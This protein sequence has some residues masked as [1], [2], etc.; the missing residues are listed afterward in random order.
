M[1]RDA[2]CARTNEL[3]HDAPDEAMVRVA[4]TAVRAPGD[5]R[6]GMEPLQFVLHPCGQPEQTRR[7]FHV[8]AQAGVRKSQQQRR[9]R[10]ESVGGAPGFL[11]A[12]ARQLRAARN[13]GVRAALRAVGRDDQIDT[14][15]LAARIGAAAPSSSA[16]AKI[17]TSVFDAPWPAADPPQTSVRAT[18]AINAAIRLFFMTHLLKRLTSRPKRSPEHPRSHR[19]FARHSHRR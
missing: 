17:A 15:T 18:T 7:V 11:G 9:P 2:Q 19:R 4:G 16:C 8:T 1:F 12:D 3:R 6:V 13:R 5:E 10:A 14:C